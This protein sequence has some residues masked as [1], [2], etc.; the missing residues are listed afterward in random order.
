VTLQQSKNTSLSNQFINQV[1]SQSG[2]QVLRQAG[3]QAP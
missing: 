3:F 1:L 2:Q